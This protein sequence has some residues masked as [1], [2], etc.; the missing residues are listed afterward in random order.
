AFPAVDGDEVDPADTG[1]H[2]VGQFLPE[3][4]FADGRLDPDRQ[5]RLVREPFYEIEHRVDIGELGVPRRADALF[6]DG[7]AAG[8]RDALRDLPSRQH[9]ADAGLVALTQL[10]LKSSY[11][12]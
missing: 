1:L 9:P 7:D 8:G 2:L 5:S 12:R 4:Q 10:D 6:P 11:R 3:G